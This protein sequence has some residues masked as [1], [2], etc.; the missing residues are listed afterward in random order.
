MAGHLI[1]TALV[2]FTAQN[3]RCFRDEARLTLTATR[4]AEE[5]AVRRLRTAGSDA[6]AVLPAAGIFGANASGKSA[7][8]AAMADMQCLA[9]GADCEARPFLLDGAS[10]ARPSR[11]EIE[12][13]LEGVRW[14][15]G[16]EIAPDGAVAAEHAFHYPHARKACV[17]RRHSAGIDFGAAHRSAGTKLKCWIRPDMLA[18]PTAA[19]VGVEAVEP[20]NRWFETNL[21]LVKTSETGWGSELTAAW[22]NDP[23]T[24]QR[25]EAMFKAADLGVTGAA[26]GGLGA[27][28]GVLACGAAGLFG[29]AP[30]V[31]ALREQSRGTQVWVEIAGPVLSALDRGDVLLIDELG[32]SLHPHLVDALVGLFQDQRTN[33][34]CAQL[35]FNTHTAS[36]LGD[37]S[38][39]RIGR[40]QV[41]FTHKA[42]DGAS[43]LY[44][45]TD[46]SPRR[47]EAISRRYLQGHYGAVPDCRPDS[48][49]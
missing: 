36:I 25:A 32:R 20:L 22:L 42:P 34:R 16:F 47:D 14:R 23:A 44:P 5:S 21:R 31:L 29:A 24:A 46:F 43:A 12:L 37:S 39:R 35:V 8:L 27:M 19:A 9:A 2:A 28:S 3:V 18:L 7:L 4:M 45:L 41:W 38:R 11:Y 48:G 26:I 10:A 13:I 49:D 17:F 1:N 6:E 40:D 30:G 15:Y 33:L